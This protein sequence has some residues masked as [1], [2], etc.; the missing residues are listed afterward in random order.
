LVR[1]IAVS[2]VPIE[3]VVN[4]E[5]YIDNPPER[6]QEVVERPVLQSPDKCKTDYELCMASA[7][8]VNQQTVLTTK[9]VRVVSYPLDIVSGAERRLAG[10]VP[11]MAP[12]QMPSLPA[13]LMT[14]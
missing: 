5:T 9:P 4:Q 6:S 11:P 12:L 8:P 14:R 10:Q 2:N 7:G 13:N 1:R 3:M